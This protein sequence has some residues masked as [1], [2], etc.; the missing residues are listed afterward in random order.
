MKKNL[1]IK[2][3]QK[4]RVDE[5][6]TEG[7]G[8]NTVPKWQLD[9]DKLEKR[10]TKLIESLKEVFSN[11]NNRS[12]DRDFIPATL[13]VGLNDVA[14]AKSHRTDIQKI[15]N[16]KHSRNN[17]IGFIDSNSLLVKIDNIEEGQEVKQNFQDYT[18]N[19]KP[20]SAIESI[21]VFK[22]IISDIEE[23]DVLKVSLIDYLNLELNN[24]VKI[25]FSK[26]CKDLNLGIKE[27]RYSPGLTVFKI[28]NGTK[29]TLDQL[30]E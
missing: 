25:A 30:T 29:A 26:F 9:A 27:I 11:F 23:Y 1:P 22:A 13:K 8:D 18:K 2:I 6:K 5:R 17:I 19:A 21:E 15:F 16:G 10:A 12:S 3:F 20:I 4:R 28:L 24:A 14:I 7:G